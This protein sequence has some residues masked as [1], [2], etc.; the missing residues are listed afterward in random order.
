MANYFE[1]ISKPNWILYQYHVDF[2]PQIES[3]RLRQAMLH[4]HDELFPQHYAFD[5]S[6]LYTLTKLPDEVKKGEKKLYF[7]I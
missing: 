6:T 1:V 4:C 5:G 3:K 7:L 2:V